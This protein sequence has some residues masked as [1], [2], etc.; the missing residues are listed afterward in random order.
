LVDGLDRAV[1]KNYG[2]VGQKFIQWI[3]DNPDAIQGAADLREDAEDNWGSRESKNS[4]L[5]RIS[6]YL[7]TLDAAA[8]FAR[9]ALGWPDCSQAEW[10]RLWD[11]Y[12]QKIWDIVSPAAKMA[13]R[14]AEAA[15]MV[16]AWCTMNEGRFFHRG[17]GSE[18]SGGFDDPNTEYKADGRGVVD[19]VGI[20]DYDA[21]KATGAVA[22][23]K[24]VLLDLL[25]RNGYYSRGVLRA[26]RDAGF[27]EVDKCDGGVRLDKQVRIGKGRIR[28]IVL[29][30]P[31]M[32]GLGSA[33][34]R[35]KESAE[36][37]DG[38]F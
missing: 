20:W 21:K 5:H 12:H 7:A 3:V 19:C 6:G 35:G 29:D 15:E 36:E 32:L 22:I 8:M 24:S 34:D 10:D 11:E 16:W 30:V 38:L 2:A 31:A 33:S 14:A 28:A 26:W 23:T 9:E 27:I 17:E 4:V 13:D 1:R 37:K 25:E 18:F